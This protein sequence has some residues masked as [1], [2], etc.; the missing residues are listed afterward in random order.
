MIPNNKNSSTIDGYVRE[1]HKQVQYIRSCAPHASILFIGPSDMSTCIDGER[2]TYPLI[3]YMDKLLEKMA[4]EEKIGY[5]SLYE[6]MGGKNSMLEWRQKGLAG[7]D[8]VHFTQAGAKKAGEM[9]SAWLEEGNI[10]Q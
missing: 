1:L 3:P 2:V 10:F 6:A 5:W 4:R 7:S 9:L 8:Y